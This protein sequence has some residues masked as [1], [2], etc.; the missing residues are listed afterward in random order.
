MFRAAAKSISLT[1]FGQVVEW[2]LN[3]PTVGPKKIE[4]D[5][6]C[7]WVEWEMTEPFVVIAAF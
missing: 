4:I 6:A 7:L 2:R 1:P 5:G 3:C